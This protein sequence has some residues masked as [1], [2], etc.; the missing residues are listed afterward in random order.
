MP[1]SIAPV[2]YTQNPLQMEQVP[3]RCPNQ[4]E[5]CFSSRL[6]PERLIR[7]IHLHTIRHKI[8]RGGRDKKWLTHWMH[9]GRAAKETV[10]H[11][12]H[13]IG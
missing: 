4:S 7:L 9:E 12:Q 3:Y 13:P 6:G 1:I 2:A 8:E 11:P 10:D 5:P